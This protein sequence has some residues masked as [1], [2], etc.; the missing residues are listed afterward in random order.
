M[1]Y[2]KNSNSNEILRRINKEYANKKRNALI[3]DTIIYTTSF[4]LFLV[5]SILLCR[6]V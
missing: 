4:I 1:H 2:F 6:M 3:L 5:F